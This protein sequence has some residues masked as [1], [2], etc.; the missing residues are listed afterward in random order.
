MHE[1]VSVIVVV[2][3]QLGMFYDL[4]YTILIQDER[5]SVQLNQIKDEIQK[6]VLRPKH[7]N[8]GMFVNST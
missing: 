4:F 6:D 1:L 3:F 5:S 2:S 7:C 8:L